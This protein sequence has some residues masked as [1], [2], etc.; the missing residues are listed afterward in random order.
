MKPTLLF[1]CLLSVSVLNAQNSVK[2]AQTWIPDNGNGTFTNPLFYDE[3]SDPDIIRVGEDFYLTGTTMH[4]VPGLPLLKSKDLVNWELL[5]YVFN[6][7][8]L[9][10]EFNMEQGKEAYGQGIWAPCIRYHNNTFYVFSNVNGHGMQVFTAKNPAGPWEHKPLNSEIYDLSVLFDD[11]GKIYAVYNYNEVHLVE[12]KPDLTG[13]VEGTDR[14]IIPAGNNMG[15]GHHMYKI[16]GK[17]YIISANYAPVGR[18]Q[19]ARADSPYGPY[20]TVAISAEETMGTQR[21]WLTQNAGYGK[22]PEAGAELGL[23][24]PGDNYLGAVTLH[25]GGI[26]DLPNGDWWGFSMMDFRS[27]GRTTCISPVTWKEGWPYF[28]LEGNPGRSPRTWTKPNVAAHS[29]PVAPYKRNDDFSGPVLSNVWQWNHNPVDNKWE[30]NAKKGSLRLHTMPAKDFLWARNTLTQRGIGPVSLATARL[31]ATSLKTG[32]YAG[33]AILN[34]PY[35]TLGIEKTQNGFVLRY[36]DQTTN[37]TIENNLNSGLISLRIRGDF[38]NDFA[39]FSYSTD[40]ENFIVIGDPV[41]M[42]YQ[43]KTFQGSRY[44]LFA[45]NRDNREGGYADFLDFNMQEPM[46]DRSANIP[47]GKIIT[48][49]NLADSSR[50]WA[51]PHGM[52]HSQSKGSKEFDGPGCRFMV[53][54]RGNGKVALEAMNGTG[55]VTVVGIGISADVRLVKK[56]TEASV[57]MWQDMLFNQLMLLSLKT[58]R[59]AGLTP[60][61]GEPYAADRPGA[62]PN[63][64]DGTVLVWK[65]AE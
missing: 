9:G 64:K 40:N 28:G 15:E 27:V 26:V 51:N 1:I 19:C 22:L 55:F 46:A 45:Y 6:K 63:R 7:F 23:T 14:I 60:G 59:Y 5:G 62:L 34:I 18:M 21:G 17:Y 61:T 29:E 50:A 25:Q 31:D 8:T 49:T 12:L 42:S 24:P 10:P 44:A 37:A 43:L 2:H 47:L 65:E 39:Q 36:Y 13:T 11:D 35:A 30:L 32:D 3:F 48:I 4:T 58:N 52:L 33:I 54:D 16:R 41:C 38:D 57:F 53:H 20:E 56:E